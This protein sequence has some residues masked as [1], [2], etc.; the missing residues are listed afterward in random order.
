MTVSVTEND[1]KMS[2]YYEALVESG[3][4]QNVKQAQDYTCLTHISSVWRIM[5]WG[6]DGVKASSNQVFQP[7]KDSLCAFNK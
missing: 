7:C 1:L 6:H 3:L 5:S 2:I 4:M